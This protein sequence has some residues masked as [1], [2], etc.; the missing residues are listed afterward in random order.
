MR[1]VLFAGAVSDCL[2][3]SEQHNAEEHREQAME[4]TFIERFQIVR[5]EMF[6]RL[7]RFSAG[8]KGSLEP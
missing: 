3:Y 5:F 4:P 8:P 2:F 6:F 7:Q 1:H